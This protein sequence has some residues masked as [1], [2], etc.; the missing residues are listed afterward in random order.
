M[1]EILAGGGRLAQ[2]SLLLA[3]L[4]PTGTTNS[5]FRCCM[6]LWDEFNVCDGHSEEEDTEL[7]DSEKFR[8]DTPVTPFS[9][10]SEAIHIHSDELSPSVA[11]IAQ[12]ASK[13]F[14]EARQGSHKATWITNEASAYSKFELERR[15]SRPPLLTSSFGEPSSSAMGSS[16]GC[17]HFSID[18][19][20]WVFGCLL[21]DDIAGLSSWA[22]KTAKA[23]AGEANGRSTVGT[24]CLTGAPLVVE[25]PQ[26][27]HHLLLQHQR[28]VVASL[29]EPDFFMNCCHDAPWAWRLEHLQAPLIGSTTPAEVT[30]G[31]ASVSGLRL[32]AS[33]QSVLAQLASLGKTSLS[34]EKWFAGFT[35]INRGG[36]GESTAPFLFDQLVAED[37]LVDEVFDLPPGN[38]VPGSVKFC[39]GEAT[40]GVLPQGSAVLVSAVGESEDAIFGTGEWNHFSSARDDDRRPVKAPNRCL[41]LGSEEV[42]LF[43]TRFSTFSTLDCPQTLLC[44]E[45]ILFAFL[46]ECY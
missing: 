6:Q 28:A 30:N 26:V 34:V 16:R 5:L 4:S 17:S 13:A 8:D 12:E 19:R 24:N 31:S 7:E 39:G 45:N 15:D 32:P 25:E 23:A 11:A 36:S 40:E 3:A 37:T 41:R 2:T 29:H 20:A 38:L 42:A 44:E 14:V 35:T 21:R 18:T 10:N 22:F 43:S 27:N 9:D 1:L 46:K 33:C